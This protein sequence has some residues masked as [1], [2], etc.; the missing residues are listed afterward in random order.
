MT[1]DS[2][3]RLRVSPVVC[4]IAMFFARLQTGGN[5]SSNKSSIIFKQLK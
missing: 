1:P 5:A 4:N 3:F 2:S